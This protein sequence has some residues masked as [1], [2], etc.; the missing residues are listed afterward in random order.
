VPL[1]IV[2]VAGCSGS[3]LTPSMDGAVGTDGAGDGDSVSWA[4]GAGDGD[5]AVNSCALLDEAACAADPSCR[6]IVI[7]AVF[8]D[9]SC[10]LPPVA[11]G[12]APRACNGPA[13]RADNG[14]TGEFVVL[15]GCL[16][17]ELIPSSGRTTLPACALCES[18]S[19]AQCEAAPQCQV[20]RAR[21]IDDLRSCVLPAQDV[22]CALFNLSC[23][24]DSTRATDPTG[25]AWSVPG[26]CVP[27]GWSADGGAF[28]LGDCVVPTGPEVCDSLSVRDCALDTSCR[29]LSA[30][31]TDAPRSCS[32]PAQPVACIRA[33]ATCAD[34][35]TRARDTN[36]GS[37]TFPSTCLPTD[38]TNITSTT[39]PVADCPSADGG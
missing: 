22:A 24:V 8:G 23:P 17:S 21:P 39:T 19:I 2:V 10:L 1:A 38:W 31:P 6:P 35:V 26:A 18:L 27:P 33:D 5:S 30:K 9:D 20:I 34:A 15:G 37:W 11:D 7:E 14:F 3:K 29:L 32:L 12:C 13:L 16:P 36:Q 28:D 4:D 25:K